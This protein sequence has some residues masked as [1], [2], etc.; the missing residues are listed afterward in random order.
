M[1]IGIVTT[2]FERGAAYVS[3][4]FMKVLQDTHNVFIYARSGESYAIGNQEWDF[5]NVHWSKKIN[6]PFTVN[7]MDK[8]EFT[9]WIK[10]NKIEAVLFNEQHWW[11]PLI[12]CYE[13]KIK[14]IGYVDYYTE[15]T[16]PLFAVYDMLICNTKKHLEAFKWH[17]G[18]KYIPWGTDTNLF[19]PNNN[20]IIR[21][22][23]IIFFHSCGMDP[24]RK[25]TDLLLRAMKLIINKKYKVIIHT[26]VEIQ[27]FY[28]ELADTINLLIEKQKL[29]IVHKTISAPGLFHMGDIY[30]YPSRLEGIGLTIAEAIS[31][32]LGVIVPDCGPMNEFIND[33]F[34][35]KVKVEKYFSR[36]DGYYWPQN[37]VDISDLAM[38]M[39]FFIRKRENIRSVKIKA[40]NFALENLNWSKN[41]ILLNRLFNELLIKNDSV[42]KD[43]LILIKKFEN[44][45][46]RK[47]NKY[48]LKYPL[49]F[50]LF[51]AI[52]NRI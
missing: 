16:V 34:G 39:D 28:P 26:Q 2:W 22:G 27:T 32:G 15:Q 7:V 6:S 29:E 37:E 50:N 48:F 11:E 52:K 13:L 8:K 9:R 38:K 17:D 43:A 21:H 23:D 12:W 1:N 3:K 31:C 41:S 20:S 36:Y 5:P 10:T 46:I 18:A 40:R 19:K 51:S 30:V 42:K 44:Y 47:Y 35:I 25:G 49:L 4:Q 24:R 45:G 14:T 33:D